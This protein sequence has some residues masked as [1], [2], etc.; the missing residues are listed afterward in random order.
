MNFSQAEAKYGPIINGVWNRESD[1]MIYYYMPDWFPVKRIYINKDLKLPLTRALLNIAN[2]KLQHEV[3]SFDGS[4]CIRAVRGYPNIMSVH[5]F[6][7]AIDMNA[8]ENPLGSPSTWSPSFVKCFTDAGFEWGGSFERLD[9]MH[10][11]LVNLW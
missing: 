7:L 6:G 1:W 2:L 10:F 5:S 9:C 8:K 4:F 3:I 11:Q